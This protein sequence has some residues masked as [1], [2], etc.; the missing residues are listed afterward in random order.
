MNV[1][2]SEQALPLREHDASTP[3]APWFPPCTARRLWPFAGAALVVVLLGLIVL[4]Q[5]EL[6][7]RVSGVE[8]AETRLR[9]LPPGD[10]IKPTLL[11]F[12]SLGADV[13]WLQVLQVLGQ[14]DVSAE[15]YAWAYQALDVITTVDPHYVY[16][17]DAGGLVLAELAGQIEWSNQLLKK[18]IM[19]NPDAWRLAFQ[20]GFNYF[21]H[22][23]DYQTAADYMA[24]AAK[25]PGRPAYVP[26]LAARLYGEAHHPELALHF[27]TAMR[28]QVTDQ[29]MATLLDRRYQEAIVEQDLL[30]LDQA[31]R[32]Y[33]NVHGAYPPTL[34][35]VVKERLLP[36]I[37]LEPFGGSYLLDSV[38]GQ[39]SSSTNSSRLRIYRLQ[40]ISPFM[41]VGITP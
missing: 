2:S 24:M 4:L 36:Q 37:P 41:H 34:E 23:H 21:F 22:L 1:M 40:E 28:Q 8:Q 35:V 20:L 7:R 29:T 12:H 10:L 32:Q 11:G 31:V 16:A 39:V 9:M 30:T 3:S 5:R 15:D 27:L 26:E 38:T 25:L 19:A 33:R 13:L 18:G 17:Y 14:R 6:D